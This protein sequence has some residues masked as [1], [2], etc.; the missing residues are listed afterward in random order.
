M[1]YERL[2]KRDKDGKINVTLM[3]AY[4]IMQAYDRLAELEDKIESGT[5]LEF[6]CKPSDIVYYVTEVDDGE[7]I[8]YTIMNGVV[9]CFNIETACKEFLARYDG[10]LTYWHNF[11]DFGKEVFTD[12][13]QAEARLKELQGE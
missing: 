4:Y 1:K 7:S 2:T 5:L 3:N 13:Y 12:K 9:D 8:H 6:P 11:L 10:G